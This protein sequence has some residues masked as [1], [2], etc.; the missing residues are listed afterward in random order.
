MPSGL[1]GIEQIREEEIAACCVA[2]IQYA[3]VSALAM[4]YCPAYTYIATAA[5]LSVG[6]IPVIAEVD[7]TFALDPAAFER[8]IT[9]LTRCVDSLA[10]AL[11]GSRSMVGLGMQSDDSL[12][13]QYL[14]G[15]N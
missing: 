11:E 9:P 1:Y 8:K 2:G 6:A 7:D 5:V 4:S 3:L 14:G 15:V 10:H 13:C 12:G